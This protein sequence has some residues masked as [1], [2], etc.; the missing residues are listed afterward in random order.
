[1]ATYKA[2]FLAHHY[3]GRIRPRA[4]YSMGLVHRWVKLARLAPRLVNLAGSA[5]GLSHL[6]KL[7]GG[8]AQE[9]KLPAFARQTFTE[10]FRARPPRVGEQGRPRV[11]LWPDTFSNHFHPAIAQAAVEVLEHAG[12]QVVIP[13]QRLCC[14]RPLYD[15]GMLGAARSLL[16]RTLAALQPHLAAGT[17]VVGLEPSCVSVFRDEMTNLLPGNQAAQQLKAHTFLL[18]EFLVNHA[19]YR[20]PRLPV[21]MV[22]VFPGGCHLMP[23]SITEAQDYDEQTR[24]RTPAIDKITGTRR[25]E[26]KFLKERR[27]DTAILMRKKWLL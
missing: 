16:E 13:E 6:L 4:A 14:G 18:S 10:W 5:P 21:S 17:P 8:I 7:A 25:S 19:N 22:Q 3:E 27:A 2:E 24:T 23:D 15:F 1:M 20:P 12:Y 26:S 9:R 11:L